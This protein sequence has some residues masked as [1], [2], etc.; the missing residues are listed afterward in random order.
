METKQCKHINGPRLPIIVWEEQPQLRCMLAN[1]FPALQAF[2][3]VTDIM[4]WLRQTML[5]E[6]LNYVSVLATFID[7]CFKNN[8]YQ[9]YWG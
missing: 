5:D 1:I 9:T 4:F 6:I 8:W 3:T 2:W 7:A